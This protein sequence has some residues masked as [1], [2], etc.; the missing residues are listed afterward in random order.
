MES[1]IGTR[2]RWLAIAAVLE[3]AHDLEGAMTKGDPLH[4]PIHA[5]TDQLGARLMTELELDPAGTYSL[6]ELVRAAR[7]QAA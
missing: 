4:G 6:E 7:E 3:A 2:Q 1:T 5:L